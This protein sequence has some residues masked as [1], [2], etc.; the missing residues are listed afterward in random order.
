[1]LLILAL[2]G[3]SRLLSLILT[4]LVRDS[5]GHLGL[6]DHPDGLRKTHS[7]AVAR[8]GGIVIAGSYIATFALALILPSP[9]TL[10]F[11]NALPD[12]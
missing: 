9:Y 12:I 3:L 2:G 8:V 7:A 5:I 11:R 1:L 10:V 6:L 4:P